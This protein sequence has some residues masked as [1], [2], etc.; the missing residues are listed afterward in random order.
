MR[1]FRR[2][3]YEHR[4][5][6]Q[7]VR[8]LRVVE[9][10]SFVALLCCLLIAFILRL[11]LPVVNLLMTVPLLVLL[12]SIFTVGV[13]TWKTYERTAEIRAENVRGR[14]LDSAGI[15]WLADTGTFRGIG[16]GESIF[17][18]MAVG[19]VFVQVV[20]PYFTPR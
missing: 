16:A 1:F 19:A 20:W 7:R 15:G 13:L 4:R 3:L 10:A 6:P 2:M 5:L 8:G 18:A 9:L 14:G 17:T 12:S 11:P